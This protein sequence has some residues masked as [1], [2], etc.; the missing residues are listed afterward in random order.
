MDAAKLQ[1]IKCEKSAN[2]RRAN[3]K[4]LVRWEISEL[5][6][7]GRRLSKW[8]QDG[9]T[10]FE[11]DLKANG[12]LLN[13]MKR[14]LSKIARNKRLAKKKAASKKVPIVV[15]DNDNNEDSLS[16]FLNEANDLGTSLTITTDSGDS[17]GREVNLDET[18]SS[19]IKQEPDDDFGVLDG[20]EPE[21]DL[22]FEDDSLEVDFELSD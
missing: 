7:R 6:K 12:K 1:R 16:D 9:L 17:N 22:K 19:N 20:N 18:S 14:L 13:D 4:G 21:L 8:V 15:T 2:R 11:C 5:E 3:Y 10:S